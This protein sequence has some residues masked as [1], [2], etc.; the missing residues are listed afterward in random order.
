MSERT[1]KTSKTEKRKGGKATQREQARKAVGKNGEADGC[2]G[3]AWK[4]EDAKHTSSD[5]SSGKH[6]D[7]NL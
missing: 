5:T 4:T 6:T 7:V 1:K 3:V 2:E